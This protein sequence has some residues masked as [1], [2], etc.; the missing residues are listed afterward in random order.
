MRNAAS[1]VGNLRSHVSFLPAMGPGPR[2]RP[3]RKFTASVS[4]APGYNPTYYRVGTSGGR[5]L[6][7]VLQDD[8]QIPN[9]GECLQYYQL[10]NE[11]LTK[12]ALCPLPY[13]EHSLM[14]LVSALEAASSEDLPQDIVL[15]A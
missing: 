4:A 2:S 10:E 8:P 14:A 5:D 7:T 13:S 1:G 3:D 12:G 9:F 15:L 11:R 6:T